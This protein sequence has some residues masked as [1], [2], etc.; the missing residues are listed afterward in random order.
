[1]FRQLW[2]QW[3]AISPVGSS[4]TGI[5][6]STVRS[7][8]IPVLLSSVL[9]LPPT[10]SGCNSSNGIAKPAPEPPV[11]V[12]VI[13]NDSIISGQIVSV[14]PSPEPFP[15]QVQLILVDSKDVE[16]YINLTKSK[17]GQTVVAK[18]KDDMASFNAG[19]RISARFKLA[20]DESGSFF[21][22]KEVTRE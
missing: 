22:L 12:P 3:V 18:T 9:L 8:Y 15:W 6:K 17:L 14:A 20:G 5:H 1:M 21:Y 4:V 16:G 7:V 2:G 11:S 13:P 10:L 19:D